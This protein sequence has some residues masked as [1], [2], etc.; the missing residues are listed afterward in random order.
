MDSKWLERTEVRGSREGALL[1]TD[2]E[3]NAAEAALGVRFPD[4][5]RE[6]V[7][8]LGYGTYN[9]F[10]RV[11]LP[12]RLL[13]ERRQWRDRIREYWFWDEGPLLL[14][15]AR[16]LECI[17]LADTMNGDD[18]IYHP[19]DP[20][21]LYVLPRHKERVFRAGTDLYSAVKWMLGSGK[22]MRSK[23]R[24]FESELRADWQAHETGAARP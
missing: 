1:A 3:V 10:L 20:A 23:L 2:E 9:V 15:Q 19:S 12:S 14:T 13:R 11:Y 24:Y 5:Y 16:A 18:L 21:T 17:V 8:E 7:K 22:L 6:Y 4:G